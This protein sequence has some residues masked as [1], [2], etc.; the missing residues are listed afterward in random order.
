[1][2]KKRSILLVIGLLA[3]IVGVFLLSYSDTFRSLL[4]SITLW[5]K[6][7]MSA[8]P[9]LGAVVFFLFS[10]LS[11]MLAFASSAA[12]VP[13]AN[14]VWGKFVTF[15]LLWGGWLSGAVLAYQIGRLA[16]PLLMRLGYKEKIH[17]YQEYVGRRTKFWMVLL[18]CFAVP[19]EIP[20][21]VLGGV[22]YSFWRFVIAMA[23]SE[24]IYAVLIVLAGESL[25]SKNPLPLVLI[26]GA[27][28]LIVGVAGMLFR[29]FRKH[30][31]RS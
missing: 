18:F 9:L 28:V 22:Q 10:M 26:L 19:S 12:L 3:L 13:P 23:I 16:R 15:L 5:A 14:L 24:G 30:R 17:K 7:L 4:D 1:M 6:D 21:Y 31:I 25:F 27:L 8:N 29:N 2:W 11:A 20:G